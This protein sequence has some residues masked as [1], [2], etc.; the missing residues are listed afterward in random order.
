[1]HQNSCA[2]YP[3]NFMILPASALAKLTLELPSTKEPSFMLLHCKNLSTPLFPF[4]ARVFLAASV[5]NFFTAGM[6]TSSFHSS[7]GL[8]PAGSLFFGLSQNSQNLRFL[9]KYDG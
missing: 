3:H 4:S 1:M 5:V 9:R 7:L 6:A 8:F 2:A